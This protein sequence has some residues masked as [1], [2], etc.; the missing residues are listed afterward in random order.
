MADPA[1]LVAVDCPSNSETDL[2]DATLRG[3]L[4]GPELGAKLGRTLPASNEFAEEP[5]S[6]SPFERLSL[7]AKIVT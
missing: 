5:P 4:V 6:E 3:L 1:R 2:N 7:F